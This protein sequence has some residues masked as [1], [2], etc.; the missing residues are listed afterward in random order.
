MEDILRII[1]LYPASGS[2]LEFL[3]LFYY[4]LT[5]QYCSEGTP[6]RDFFITFLNTLG[7][8]VRLMA[9]SPYSLLLK[10]DETFI[11]IISAMLVDDSRAVEILH[12]ETL[13]RILSTNLRSLILNSQLY[14]SCKLV[15]EKQH[16]LRIANFLSDRQYQS[17]D[18]LMDLFESS[19]A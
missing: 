1:L 6:R 15:H 17:F 9:A 14:M 2:S 8:S 3:T 13:Q 18:G 16:S 5:E 11:A 10:A 12:A 4:Q 7:W 19:G